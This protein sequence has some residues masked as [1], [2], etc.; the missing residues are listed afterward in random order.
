MSAVPPLRVL[1]VD[2][3]TVSR[4]V[5][6]RMLGG[7]GHQVTEAAD[8]P[9]AI[10]AL[11][12]TP[13]DLVVSDYKMPS[14]TGLDVAEEARRRR[15]PF[16]LLTGFSYG[17][18]FEQLDPGLVRVHLAKPVSSSELAAAV[19][20]CCGR[21]AESTP[22]SIGGGTAPA[23]APD[24]TAATVPSAS[25]PAAAGKTA[26]ADDR[27]LVER[28]LALLNA[29]GVE[30]TLADAGGGIIGSTAGRRGALGYPESFWDDASIFDLTHPDDLA[31]AHE[32][33]AAIVATPGGSAMA[34][35]RARHAEGHWEMVEIH[36]TNLLD[37][38]DVGAL[39]MTSRSVTIEERLRAAHAEAVRRA[40]SQVQYVASV[41]HEL[42][43][44]LQ[45]ILG[46]AQL[47]E[48]TV[49]DG[50][51]ELVG[52]IR[53][54]AERLR[55]VID[56]ILDYAKSDNGAV[57]LEPRPTS[58]A[59]LVGDVSDICQ[60][61]LQPGVT[62]RVDV[63]P[64]VAPWVEIDD[65]RLHQIL[66][67]LVANA[68]RFTPQGSITVS[69]R[70]LGGDRLLFDVIDT[71]A[72][73]APDKIGGLF[74]P[75]RQSTRAEGGGGAGLGLS[76]SRN[77]VSIMGGRL[78][79][80][81]TVGEGS[82][83]SFAVNATAIERPAVTTDDG[84]PAPAA[85]PSP[86][87]P[88]PSRALVVDDSSVN[89]MVLSK[90]LALMGF[91]VDTADGGS[92][93]I[94]MIL[95]GVYDVVV[96]DWHMPEVD[97]LD[98]IAAVRS[99]E[100]GGRRTP[101]ITVTASAMT[102]DRKRCLD[103]GADGFLP[104]PVTKAE[105]EEVVSCYLR[106]A[107]PTVAGAAGRRDGAEPALPE[108]GG[109]RGRRGDDA[110]ATPALDAAVLDDLIEQLGGREAVA[111]VVE[112]FLTEIGRLGDTLVAALEDGHT[113]AAVT[114]AHT[115]R[116]PSQLLGATALGESCTGIE[117]RTVGIDRAS[118]DG[119]RRRLERTRNALQDWL[120]GSEVVA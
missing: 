88:A 51:A 90:Q 39:V 100:L 35:F 50:S 65:L 77:L 92:P 19:E 60:P 28:N 120:S 12:A 113:D 27:N 25:E 82:T 66:L 26:A 104:K 79:V 2:D 53:S 61:Q 15:T 89:R 67:N 116:G 18:E 71:G 48:D 36:G 5:V 63:H 107:A 3:E 111:S 114:A 117:Q 11:R 21:P 16:I 47:L 23:A 105:R 76:I 49:N 52:I 54:E 37:D 20:T 74:E 75:F 72:G 112:S 14:G 96:T 59:K 1:A 57:E 17:G 93:G 32:T 33:M 95:D 102:S 108:D 31:T 84:A 78:S 4:L 64:S 44:P 86:T 69:C 30:V 9:E 58:I 97:G 43:S 83:F 80:E 46:V 115:L 55:R 101:I 91:E 85:A 99:A 6:S 40:S 7:L 10:E 62:I 41:S 45:G 42:R 118:A 22:S 68:A 38:P 94:A 109:D 98:L 34:R 87:P 110:P 73:I 56:D 106:T 81:S 13:F 70:P 103:A 8:A 119:L 24:P 29:I